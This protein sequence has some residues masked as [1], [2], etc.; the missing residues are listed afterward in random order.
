MR[1]RR[2]V[3]PAIVAIVLAASQAGHL[4]ATELRR[5]PR[6]LAVDGTGV[7]GY[8]PALASVVLGLGGAAVLAALLV[9]AAARIVRTGGRAAIARPAGESL[10]N[11]S[12]AL[13]ATQLG[14]YVVQETLEAAGR[15]GLP[16]P[17]ELLLWGCIGQLPVAVLAAVILRWLASSF[18]AAVAELA[19]RAGQ[20]LAARTALAPVH[21]WTAGRPAF[22]CRPAGRAASVRGPPE[23]LCPA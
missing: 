17:G 11:V 10:L 7:H 12:A 2:L 6:A 15:T 18:E 9:V 21:R 8:V 4:L 13:F 14:I 19:A 16:S 22:R 20:P 1:W 23:L 5:G 3:R